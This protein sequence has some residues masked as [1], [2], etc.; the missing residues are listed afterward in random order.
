MSGG[1]S[2]GGE[3]ICISCWTSFV[4]DTSGAGELTCPH[5]GYLQPAADEYLGASGAAPTDG[6]ADKAPAEPAQ[7]EHARAD[8]DR[9][10]QD[11]RAPWADGGDKDKGG[12]LEPISFDDLEELEELL[13]EDPRTAK[14]PIKAP[15]MQAAAPKLA[16]VPPQPPQPPQ[17]SA[18]AIS[19]GTGDEIDDDEPAP[20]Q[21]AAADSVAAAPQARVIW[22]LKSATGMTYSF[23]DIEALSRWATGLSDTKALVLS[24]DGIE[25]K[26]YGEFQSALSKGDEAVAAFAGSKATQPRRVAA[27]E[28]PAPA[29]VTKNSKRPEAPKRAASAVRQ[30]QRSRAVARATTTAERKR[31]PSVLEQVAAEAAAHEDAKSGRGTR[32]VERARPNLQRQASARSTG[33]FQIRQGVVE[34]NPWPSRLAFMGL[35]LV[36]GGATVYFGLYLLGFYDL[37]FTF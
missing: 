1:V 28:A 14:K 35:G 29:S 25:W 31:Q 4:A 11:M 17:Q 3:Y 34:A 33:N 19:F 10:M 16:A 2:E 36:L 30:T 12:G 37:S 26:A 9:T 5:C 23:F 7:P 6:K 8:L 18:P 20:A 27:K 15:N 32:T 24:L 22:K 13:S 21:A